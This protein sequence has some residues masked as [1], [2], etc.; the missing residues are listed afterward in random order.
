MNLVFDIG[1]TK[2]RLAVVKDGEIGEPKK[3][4]TPPDF[5]SGL[6]ALVETARELSNGEEIGKMVGGIAGVMD[7]DGTLWRAPHIK[8]W[9]GHNLAEEL[10]T[11]LDCE[12]MVKND[13]SLGGLGEATRGAGRGYGIVAY[14]TISTGVGGVK[15]ENGQIDE[16]TFGFEPGHQIIDFSDHLSLEDLVSGSAIAAKYNMEP[17]KILD[18]KVWDDLA[19]KLAAGLSNA[20]TMWS[21]EVIILGGPM[22]LGEV[23]IPLDKIKSYFQTYANLFPKL[24]EIKKSELGDLCTLYGALMLL[25]NRQ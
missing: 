1:G 17:K 20:T 3:I 22:I 15:I 2:T 19:Q 14:L 4:A 7:K 8:E 11:A 12:A 9:E 5:A 25:K 24:P 6:K 10:E 21:P 13:A 23:G 16:A 18:D